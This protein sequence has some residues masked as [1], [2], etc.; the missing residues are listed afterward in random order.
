MI[1]LWQKKSQS[2]KF[3][4]ILSSSRVVTTPPPLLPVGKRRRVFMPSAIR[5]VP[6]T[7]NASLLYLLSTLN[8]EQWLIYNVFIISMNDAF[9]PTHPT[10][11]ACN[12]V[13]RW[14]T[15]GNLIYNFYYCTLNKI[16]LFV[17][18][19]LSRCLSVYLS[20]FFPSISSSNLFQST[21]NN[22]LTHTHTCIHTYRH[23]RTISYICT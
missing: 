3:A 12:L 4:T 22:L 16:L 5:Q 23:A 6:S 7:P 18:L 13:G 15:G 20:F 21:S 2:P 1:R 10:S 17:I 14:V 9:H 11:T 19:S 8:Q